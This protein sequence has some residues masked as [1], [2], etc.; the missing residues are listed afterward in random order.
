MAFYEHDPLMVDIFIW[1]V[2]DFIVP[3]A[4]VLERICYFQ[5]EE[6]EQQEEEEQQEE[7]E[8]DDDDDSDSTSE[9]EEDEHNLAEVWRST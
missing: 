4:D 7:Q 6:Q 9:E 1:Y 3:R 5:E 8:Q 2:L